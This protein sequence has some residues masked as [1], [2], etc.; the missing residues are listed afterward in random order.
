MQ[1]H[2]HMLSPTAAPD[3]GALRSERWG[4]ERFMSG[5]LGCSLCGVKTT[6]PQP[7]AAGRRTAT[8]A[9]CHARAKREP[10]VEG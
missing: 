2:M 3:G 7:A 5:V 9:V 10:F 4:Y 1:Q 8:L 6:G